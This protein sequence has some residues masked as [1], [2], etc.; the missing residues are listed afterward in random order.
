MKRFAFAIHPLDMTDVARFEPKAANKRRSVVEKVLEWTP[1]YK[2]SHITGLRSDAGAEA[3]GWFIAVPFLPNQLLSFPKEK[4][5]AKILGAE[6]VARELGAGILG[7]GGYTSVVSRGGTDVAKEA[8][9]AVTTGNSF[10]VW[11]AMEGAFEG[12][13][14]LGIDPS[15]ATATIVGASGSIGNVIARLIAPR[16]RQL[17][18]VARNRIRL[19]RIARELTQETG[20]EVVIS[21]ELAPSLSVSDIVISAT[22]SGGQIIPSE[23]LK[24][25][26]IVCDVSLP[27]DVCREVAQDRPDVLV[28][29]GG[30]VEVPGGRIDLGFDIGYPPGVVLACMAETMILCL[31][32]K[33]ED[34]SLGLRISIA[35][36][37]EIRRLAAKHGFR[38]AGFRSFGRPVSEEQ[39]GRV[40]DMA[41][42][43]R[44]KSPRIARRSTGG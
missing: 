6:K 29:E 19:T 20:R 13:R 36:I 5:M 22:S 21:T 33:L 35:E 10:T 26:A 2:L 38:L 27:Y 32:G 4:V 42:R 44:Q 34:F 28:I 43:S 39:I 16:V 14:L 15:E 3:E 11:T 25:G 18:L 41:A 24:A 1:P 17:H 7:L 40:R 9:I 31:E 37:E 8:A 12:A 23:C 30:G